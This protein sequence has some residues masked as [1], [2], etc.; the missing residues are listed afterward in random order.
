VVDASGQQAGPQRA[1]APRWRRDLGVALAA[2]AATL[3]VVYGFGLGP[4]DGD[5]SDDATVTGD[6]PAETTTTAAAEPPAP[7]DTFE[8]GLHLVGRD[9][10][11]GRYIAVGLSGGCDWARLADVEGTQPIAAAESLDGQ[12]VVEISPDDAAFQS[13]SCGLW[14]PYTPPPGPPT[15]TMSDGDWVVGE[16]VEP[17][18]YQSDVAQAAECT[19]TRAS[20]FGHTADQVVESHSELYLGNAPPEVVELQA[21]DLFSSQ[22]CQP[23]TKVG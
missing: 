1:A 18:T 2:V 9:I 19:W 15:T 12:A 23:W 10:E 21:G 7:V 4:S 20:G 3:A 16:Q 14:E 5:D 22:Q 6:D 8:D 13:Q 17:G 11:P